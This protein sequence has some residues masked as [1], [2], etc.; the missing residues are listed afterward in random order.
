MCALQAVGS[1]VPRCS[2]P[3]PPRRSYPCALQACR[4]LSDLRQAGIRGSRGWTVSREGEEVASA[5]I[6]EGERKRVPEKG[7]RGA[8]SSCCT[9][10]TK[11]ISDSIKLLKVVEELR[12]V[13]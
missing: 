6:R 10:A 2:V 1:R 4:H 3:L 13:N 8:S 9:P 11:G 5:Q 12:F 7:R